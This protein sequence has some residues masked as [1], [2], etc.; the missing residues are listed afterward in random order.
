MTR[1]F[2]SRQLNK[3]GF[4][5]GKLGTNYIQEILE[6]VVSEGKPLNN[7]YMSQLYEE[8]AKEHHTG[9]VNVERNIRSAIAS[10]WKNTQSATLE[11]FYPYP[12]DKKKGKPTNREFLVNMADRLTT[13]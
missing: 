5:N 4:S 8:I 9:A 6:R 2:I 3:I 11:R 1:Q 12:W 7:S 13:K 10:T